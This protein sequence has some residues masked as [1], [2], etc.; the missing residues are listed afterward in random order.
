MKKN[1]N[2]E[3][4]TKETLTAKETAVTA[5]KAGGKAAVASFLGTALSTVVLSV[6]DTKIK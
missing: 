1:K 5:V 6:L 2:T 4:E 3:V